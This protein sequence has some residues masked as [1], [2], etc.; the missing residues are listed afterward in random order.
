[1]ID[2]DQLPKKYFRNGLASGAFAVKRQINS[3]YSQEQIG[4]PFREGHA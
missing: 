4:L 2:D 3:R 1:M